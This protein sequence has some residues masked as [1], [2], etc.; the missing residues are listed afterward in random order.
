MPNRLKS[1]KI[2]LIRVS[3]VRKEEDVS[4]KEKWIMAAIIAAGALYLFKLDALYLFA[5]AAV[6][7]FVS[8][9]R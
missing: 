9:S 8:R 2:A 4:G 7:Y 1:T 6:I 5:V 3:R